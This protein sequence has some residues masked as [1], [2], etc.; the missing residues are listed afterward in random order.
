ME[1]LI[2]RFEHKG[3]DSSKVGYDVLQSGEKLDADIV[4]LGAGVSPKT[5]YLKESGIPLDKDGGISVLNTMQVA[6]LENVYAVGMYSFN[7][8]EIEL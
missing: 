3:N 6:N 7:M 2:Y 1:S 8:Q 4:I 5:D